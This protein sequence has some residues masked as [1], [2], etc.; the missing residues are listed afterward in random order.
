MAA[1]PETPGSPDSA[2]S[3]DALGGKM[4]ELSVFG[5]VFRS[6]CNSLT[7]MVYGEA[8]LYHPAPNGQGVLD[9]YEVSSPTPPRA[10]SAL[11]LP[12]ISRALS[13]SQA[14]YIQA[15]CINHAQSFRYF[16]NVCKAMRFREGEGMPGRMIKFR[17]PEW[18][19]D[20]S[21][22]PKKV[23]LRKEAAA[24]VGFK[25][26]F[27]LP[28][29]FQNGTPY[30]VLMFF[31]FGRHEIDPVVINYAFEHATAAF[32]P[33]GL[34]VGSTAPLFNRLYV[35]PQDLTVFE[36]R[37]EDRT[38]AELDSLSSKL[39]DLSLFRRFEHHTRTFCRVARLRKYLP[40]ETVF[41]AGETGTT[42]YVIVKGSVQILEPENLQDGY[43]LHSSETIGEAALLANQVQRDVTAI[44]LEETWMLE[45]D[46]NKIAPAERPNGGAAVTSPSKP[47]AGAKAEENSEPTFLSDPDALPTPDTPGLAP[48]YLEAMLN[49]ILSNP[50]PS[51][52]LPPATPSNLPPSAGPS[53]STPNPFALFNQ[54]VPGMEH[55]LWDPST[56]LNKP[57][58]SPGPGRPAPD[59]S[60][61]GLQPPAAVD[62]SRFQP[63]PV[64]A[65]ITLQTL[66]QLQALSPDQ[67]ASSES[68]SAR[69]PGLSPQHPSP[70]PG[71]PLDPFQLDG[72]PTAPSSAFPGQPPFPLSA[73]PGAPLRP[74][75]IPRPG[76]GGP[77]ARH[78]AGGAAA[79]AAAAVTAAAF[80][81]D[82][83]MDDADGDGDEDDVDVGNS[84]GGAG[85]AGGAGGPASASSSSVQ[86][87]FTPGAPGGSE[88]RV[89]PKKK[90]A[91]HITYE[92]LAQH[93]TVPIKEASAKLGF[94]TTTL[95]KLCRKFGV[96]KWPFR[97]LAVLDDFVVSCISRD[98][99]S[100]VAA[101]SAGPVPGLGL[102]GASSATL[103]AAAAAAAAAAALRR[104]P[105]R[106]ACP[107]RPHAGRHPGGRDG[108]GGAGAPRRRG[109]RRR[110]VVHE[111]ANA[112]PSLAAAAAAQAQAQLLE[113]FLRGVTNAAAEAR[114]NAAVA[115]AAAVAAATSALPVPAPGPSSSSSSSSSAPPSAGFSPVG[116]DP[117]SLQRIRAS[118]SPAISG[119]VSDADLQAYVSRSLASGP[120]GTPGHLPMPPGQLHVPLSGIK[121]KNSE[122]T[123]HGIGG[124]PGA[125][126]FGGGPGPERTQNL[127]PGVHLQAEGQQKGRVLGPGAFFRGTGP[128]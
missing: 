55:V 28:L 4:S 46:L 36:K 42:S 128:S 99:C 3:A 16:R 68:G 102:A 113:T 27:G 25:A 111:R 118:L 60:L 14:F 7:R 88:K 43:V 77:G 53:V 1:E 19:V 90:S 24:Q 54:A 20:V 119:S 21:M 79:A 94:S 78:A 61:G 110:R 6:V 106:R 124:G 122:G 56:P 67:A 83:D 108:G 72:N 101:S 50:N 45:I 47:G 40:Y 97:Q 70:L 115:T 23:F 84:P 37:E 9:C 107:G 125:P 82:D 116:L 41:K 76:R 91:A 66:Q 38:D 114:Q 26:A 32:S 52:S 98:L 69:S 11:D 123:L 17:T 10:L 104:V 87:T 30:G 48:G 121:R 34:V 33:F 62:M 89:R 120:L 15:A 103:G 29:F 127:P 109:R 49:D 63:P 73:P 81:A 71:P 126:A 112:N 18:L 75:A 105:G 59:R 117:A 100:S 5:H 51:P 80:T 86:P 93:F 31:S 44:T 65:P 96:K 95:K 13:A 8:W 22:Y 74:G 35:N 39:K 85:G 12:L 58:E 2:S 57:P 92:V 64:P